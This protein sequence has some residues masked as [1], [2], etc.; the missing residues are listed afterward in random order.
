MPSHL[1]TFPDATPVKVPSSSVTVGLALFV[2]AAAA[3]DAS[4]ACTVMIDKQDVSFM[5]TTSTIEGRWTNERLPL[6]LHLSF[7]DESYMILR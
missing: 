2:G 1:L 7:R 4:P 5:T 6:H 3:R